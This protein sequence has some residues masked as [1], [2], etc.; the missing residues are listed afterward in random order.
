MN[1]K[2]GK[3]L[4]FCKKYENDLSKYLVTY[5]ERRKKKSLFI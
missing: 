3:T 4:L 2:K 5:K 1:P